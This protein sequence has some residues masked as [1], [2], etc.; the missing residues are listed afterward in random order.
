MLATKID[1]DE[2]C[3]RREID[4]KAD[5]IPPFGKNAYTDLLKVGCRE[6]EPEDAGGLAQRRNRGKPTGVLCG[7]QISDDRRGK[8]SRHLGLNENRDQ[9]SEAGARGHI[10]CRS[11]QKSESTAF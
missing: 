3:Q 4:Q 5:E 10:Q 2:T 1:G 11:N 8:N 6:S 9:Q 7:R